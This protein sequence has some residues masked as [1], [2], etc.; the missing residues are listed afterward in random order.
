[1]DPTEKLLARE[2]ICEL[3]AE[4]CFL[5]DGHE[6]VALAALFELGGSWIS[7]NGEA[8]GRDAIADFLSRLVPAPAPGTRRKHL[9]TN[10]IIGID[11]QSAHVKSNFLV[12]RDTPAGPVVAVAGTYRDVVVSS[13][14]QWLFRRRELFH[15]IAGESG[16]N[17]TQSGSPAPTV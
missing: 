16:L 5:L 12:I 4:Y 9:T 1:M 11:G 15:D 8:T 14:G 13:G 3:L 2:A 7:R 10:I 6:L 17:S